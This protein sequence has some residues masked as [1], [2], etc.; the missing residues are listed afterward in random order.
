LIGLSLQI[1][2][3]IPV[4]LKRSYTTLE[5]FGLVFFVLLAAA[6]FVLGEND[7][8]NLAQWSAALS[9]GCLAAVAWVTIALGDPFTRQ[10]GRRTVPK[11]W[12]TSQLFLSSTSSIA[13][14]WSIAFSCATAISIVGALTGMNWRI[15]QALA[16][17][18]MLLAI[19][20]HARVMKA[21]QEEAKRLL[22]MKESAGPGDSQ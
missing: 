2:F 4:A 9:Y 13:L 10:Y 11:E 5:V 3:F 15:L 20:W 1:I 16:L 22:E 14:G 6:S 17:G 18:C 19:L 8:Q 21:T 12:W 7:L